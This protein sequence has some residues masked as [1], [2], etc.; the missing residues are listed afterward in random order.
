MAKYV[1]AYHGGGMAETEAEQAAVMAAWES[2]MGT[3]ASSLID[4]GNPTGPAKTVGAGGAV[5]DGGGVN[6]ITG[7]GLFNADSLDAAVEIA[8]ECPI[9]DSGGSVEVAEAIEM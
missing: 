4:G 3:H 1:F 5:T 2:W 6:P 7:Y 8:K 9:L